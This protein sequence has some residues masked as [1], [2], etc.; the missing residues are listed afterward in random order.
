MSLLLCLRRFTLGD[1]D[2]L[3]LSTNSAWRMGDPG[4][5]YANPRTPSDPAS[6]TKR[7]VWTAGRC[8]APVVQGAA[9]C[10]SSSLILSWCGVV[11]RCVTGGH[12]AGT[13]WTGR[14]HMMVRGRLR[15]P[16]RAPRWPPGPPRRPTRAWPRP[17]RS[18]RLRGPRHD[19]PATGGG[20]ASTWPQSRPSSRVRE[21]TSVPKACLQR[22]YRPSRRRPGARP[23]RPARGRSRRSRSEST[24]CGVGPGAGS[25]ERRRGRRFDARRIVLRSTTRNG[26]KEGCPGSATSSAE[27]R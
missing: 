15:R 20:P 7:G 17:A 11:G 25:G 12:W 10:G 2:R 5:T 8:A 23:P 9:D 22:P 6:C 26:P 3:P 19:P 14:E 21:G 4:A 18:R 13:R 24:A 1:R 27:S 16:W